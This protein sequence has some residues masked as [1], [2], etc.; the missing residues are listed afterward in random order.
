MVKGK[1]F[2]QAGVALV[3]TLMMMVLV[4]GVLAVLVFAAITG[5]KVS[6]MEGAYTNCLE[7]AKGGGEVIISMLLHDLQSPDGILNASVD[8]STC[9]KQKMELE[10]AKW[11]NCSSE[12]KSSNPYQK[13]DVVFDLGNI[14]IRGKIIDTRQ[15]NDYFYYNITI[16]ADDVKTKEKAQIFFLYELER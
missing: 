9:F 5:T 6:R 4:T 12:A 11:L 16:A 8:N 14:R 15:T 2:E 3:T 10:T 13:P 1:L 7:A